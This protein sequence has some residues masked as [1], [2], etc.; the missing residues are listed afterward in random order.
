MALREV[1]VSRDALL[2]RNGSH[3][4]G[5]FWSS[6]IVDNSE[7]AGGNFPAFLSRQGQAIA[8]CVIVS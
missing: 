4:K 8:S 7:T 2:V 1:G 3:K 6:E 5:A